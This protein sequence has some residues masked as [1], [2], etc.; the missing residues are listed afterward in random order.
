MEELEGGP[1]VL[2]RESVWK[3]RQ[4]SWLAHPIDLLRIFIERIMQI[5]GMRSRYFTHT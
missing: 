2:R 4:K 5:S 3:S 1:A